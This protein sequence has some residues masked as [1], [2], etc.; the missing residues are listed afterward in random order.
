MLDRTELKKINK[1]VVSEIGWN[2]SNYIR[3]MAPADPLLYYVLV[4]SAYLAQVNNIE[5]KEEL[6]SFIETKISEQRA[7]FIKELARENLGIAIKIAKAFSEN[8]LL[9]YLYVLPRENAGRDGGVY[10]TPESI[11]KLALKILDIKEDD[12]VA[13][14]GSGLGDFITLA[15]ENAEQKALYGVERH[16]YICEASRIRTELFA[17]NA[18]IELGDMFSIR[19]DRKF[20]KIFSNYP[21]GLRLIHLQTG[22]EY[23]DELHKRMP[24]IKKATSSDW[25][26]NSLIFDHLSDKGRAVAI[27]TN[28]STWNSI[29]Q[30]I[31]EFFIRNGLIE[32]VI[33]L[34]AK[35][36][37]HTAIATTMIVISKGN[38]TV[39]MVDATSLCEQGRRQN[40]ISDSDIDNIVRLLNEDGSETITVNL[41]TFQE[42]DFVLNPSRYLEKTISIEDGV[43]F[44]SL[45][46]RITRGAPLRASELDALV[47][48]EPTDVQYLMLANIQNGMISE[49]LPFLK[50]VDSK[51]DKYC[52]GHRNLL[53]SKNGAPFKVAVAEIE[54]GR[55]ILGNGNLFIIELD[56]EKVNPYFI[57]AFLDSE[58]GA[59]VLKSITVGATIPNISAESL[60]KLIVPL[61]SMEKQNE[62]ANLYQAKQDEIKVLQLKIQKAQNELRGIFGE[63]D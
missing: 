24:E 42:N 40:I 39:K 43:E 44:G 18:E 50:E 31:R 29:D 61:P 20:D 59:S 10:E 51:L 23:I 7:M 22:T 3:G 6:I 8:D 33:A 28:G 54:E 19:E 58:V 47:S 35:I 27:M 25:I 15:A 11:S 13:D 38:K 1:K 63:V 57:K 5:D 2:I 30:K 49:D 45:M 56:E 16:T 12:R 46:K 9:A 60:K 55:K 36:F 62:I 17:P 21:F 4:Y 34:P 52:I 53:L 41:S 37:E 48:E 14:F 32:A 26:F